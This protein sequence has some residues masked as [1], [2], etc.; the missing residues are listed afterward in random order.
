MSPPLVVRPPAWHAV[1]V[2]QISS[3]VTPEQPVDLYPG[4]IKSVLLTTEQIQARIGEL[5][6]QIGN[7]YRVSVDETGQDGLFDLLPTESTT[8]H[9]STVVS[10]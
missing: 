1:G 3:A 5:G 10:A 6:E 7:D 9:L 4:D 8:S 2:A